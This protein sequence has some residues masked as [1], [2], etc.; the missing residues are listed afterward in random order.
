M[1]L[2]PITPGCRSL[3]PNKRWCYRA[4]A[5]W[6][7]CWLMVCCVG[8]IGGR[9]LQRRCSHVS[10]LA[11]D[12]SVWNTANAVRTRMVCVAIMFARCC[13]PFEWSGGELH[14]WQ[15]SMTSDLRTVDSTPQLYTVSVLCSCSRFHVTVSKV[16]SKRRVVRHHAY[17]RL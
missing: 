8:N 17:S 1:V 13:V 4:I 3:Y 2:S 9:G 15:T 6:Q 10:C 14:M 16:A 7:M 12:T 5:I 11:R